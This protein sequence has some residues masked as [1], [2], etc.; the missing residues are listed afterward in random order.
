MIQSSSQTVPGEENSRTVIFGKYEMGKVLGHGTFAKVYLARNLETSEQVAVKVVRKDHVAKQGMA[1]QIQREIAVMR[2]ARHRNVVE[3][4]EVM[5]TK[6]KIFFV[7]EY[8]RGGELL[9]RVAAEG[10]LGE[11]EA[12]RYFRQLVGAVEFCHGRGIFHRDLKLENLLLD[13]DGELKVSDFGLSALPEQQR[14]DGL[15]HTRC[16]TPAY[17]APEVLRKKGYDGAKADVWSCGVILYAIL[18]GFL[19]FREHNVVY[20]YTKLLKAEYTFP[21][22]ISPAARSLISKILVA[23]PEKRISIPAI[24]K[25]PWFLAGETPAPIPASIPGTSGD[26]GIMGT[27]PFFNAFELISSMASGFDLSSLFGGGRSPGSL[28]TSRLSAPAVV[29]RLVAAFEDLDF[30]VVCSKE[31]RVR[32][33][34]SSGGRAAGLT[35]TAEVFEVAPDLT[36]VEFSLTA[37]DASE[38]KKFCEE[39]ARRALNGVIWT[40]QGEEV[41]SNCQR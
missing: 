37:G 28:F 6:R 35:V 2:L 10:R 33:Q 40:W 34:R 7:M 8:V 23:D 13:E 36:V 3:L 11:E 38:Y 22:W 39:D 27:P 15:L 31:Y 20:M 9:A 41:N 30:R 1:E 29:E 14:H 12:R 32:M 24:K 16:G 19:P 21:P 18:A 4:R 17:V 25:S 26:G 5:A